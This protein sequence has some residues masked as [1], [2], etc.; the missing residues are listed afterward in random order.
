ISRIVVDGEEFV[1]EERILEGIGRIRDIEEA[2][3]GY[4]YFSNE[5]NGTINRIL[6]VE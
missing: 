2:P 4:I 1:K 5:S 3:D 6:P